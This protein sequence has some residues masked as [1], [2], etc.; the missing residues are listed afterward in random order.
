MRL[1]PFILLA[2]CSPLLLTACKHSTTQ[3]PK[4]YTLDKSSKISSYAA[5][6]KTAVEMRMFEPEAYAGKMCTVRI[7]IQRDGT[8][9]SAIAEGGDPKLCKAAISAVTHAKIPPAPDENTWQIFKNAPL[10]FRP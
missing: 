1:I 3:P 5:A 7:S 8:L 2:L 9:N 6:I 4:I 10:D